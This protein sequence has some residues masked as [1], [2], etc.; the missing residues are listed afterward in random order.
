MLIIINII[1]MLLNIILLFFLGANFISA[2]LGWGLAL[3]YY[4][5]IIYKERKEK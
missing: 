4:C 1:I 3:S 5:L 2:G